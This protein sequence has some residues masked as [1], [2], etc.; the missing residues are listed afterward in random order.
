LLI[1][2]TEQSQLLVELIVCMVAWGTEGRRAGRMAATLRTY[3][4][5]DG[6]KL[7]FSPRRGWRIG[8][9]LGFGISPCAIPSPIAMGP[10]CAAFHSL[11]TL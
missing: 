1:V 2:R 4:K 8:H 7:A 5:A 6:D 11:V 9:G 10:D 3:G